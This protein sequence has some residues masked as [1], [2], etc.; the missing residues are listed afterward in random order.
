VCEA[1]RLGNHV[2]VGNNATV[3]AGAEVGD[4][5][6]VAANAVVL[7]DARIPPYSFMVGVPASV[8]GRVTEEQ[9]ARNQHT[10]EEYCGLG[11]AYRA[12]GR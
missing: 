10:M 1:H 4:Y 11:Q 9:L 6:I 3:L 2:L 7:S 5:A 12:E 8:K